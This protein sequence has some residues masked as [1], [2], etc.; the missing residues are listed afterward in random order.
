MDRQ[1]REG[2]ILPDFQGTLKGLYLGVCRGGIGDTN[3]MTACPP[4]R[5]RKRLSRS[6]GCHRFFKRLH[7]RQVWNP[8]PTRTSIFL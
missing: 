2:E 6:G 4:P 1:G 7:P 8:L 3:Q 5:E